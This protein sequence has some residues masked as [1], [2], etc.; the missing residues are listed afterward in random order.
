MKEIYTSSHMWQLFEQSFIQDMDIVSSSSPVNPA[1]EHY[2]TN[3]LMDIITTFFKSP[4]SDQSTTV[5]VSL[6]QNL[7]VA[8]VTQCNKKLNGIIIFQF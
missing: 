1:L 4:F 7:N 6:I 3:T 2:V 8:K 5:Q